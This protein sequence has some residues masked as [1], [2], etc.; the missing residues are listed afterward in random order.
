M[1]CPIDK[2]RIRQATAADA[3]QLC[4]LLSL[5]F[6]QEADFKPDA[7]RQSRGLRLILNQPEVGLIYCATKGKF[8]IGMVS[9]LFTVSTAEGGRAAWLEDMVVHP[10]WRGKS[11]GGQLLHKAINRVR[12]AGCTRITLLTDSINGAA[13]HFYEKAGFIRSGMI[14]LRLHL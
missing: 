4:K 14:P 10:D 9:I 6:A 12:T 7:R 3:D 11:I 13:I 2:V 5:L 1:K 8:V